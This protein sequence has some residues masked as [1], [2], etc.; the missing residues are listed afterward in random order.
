M[1]KDI[2][3]SVLFFTGILVSFMLGYGMDANF[4]NN[5]IVG[6]LLAS[7]ALFGGVFVV[8]YKENIK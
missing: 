7:G 5:K 6:I 1:V 3:I 8:L 2:I 4:E